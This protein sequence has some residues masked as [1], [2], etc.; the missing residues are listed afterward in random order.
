MNMRK[1]IQL[2]PSTTVVSLPSRWVKKH[3]LVKGDE[4]QVQELENQ[5]IVS[6]QK[7]HKKSSITIDLHPFPRVLVWAQCDAAYIAGYDQIT[8]L[9]SH[10]Q[11]DIL[12]DVKNEI[13]GMMITQ[14][15]KGAITFQDITAG[16]AEEVQNI[17]TRILHMISDLLDQASSYAKQKEWHSLAKVKEN[18]YIINSYVS[19][20]QRQINK[21]GFEK[22]YSS[23]LIVTFLKLCEVFADRICILSELSASSKTD[24]AKELAQTLVTWRQIVLLFLGYSEVK[25]IGCEKARESISAGKLKHEITTLK[26]S[27]FDIIEVIIQINSK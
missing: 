9:Y 25:L 17:I 3:N 23:N 16:K 24:M 26:S 1:L 15:K 6:T 7:Q 22:T 11:E 5:L 4:L 8:F 20:A 10:S 19:Y 13:P 2:S 14:R 12:E 18:D 27:I 21:F